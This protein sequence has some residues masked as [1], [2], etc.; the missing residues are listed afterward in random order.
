[1]GELP[2]TRNRTSAARQ[3]AIR[4][5]VR[6]AQGIGFDRSPSRI[7]QPSDADALFR[8]L[9][10]PGIHA[11]IYNLPRPLTPESVGAFIARKQQQQSDGVGRLL[12]RFDTHGEVLGYSEFDVWPEWGAGD[13]G[14]ALR[15]DQQGAR[16]GVN[17]AKQTFDW[18][19][20]VLRL[21]LV[22]ATGALDNIR[23]ARL[24]DDLGLA[25]KGEI[26]STREDG[27]TRQSIVWEVTK[28][29]W[30]GAKA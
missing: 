14:G 12:L 10:D 2:I 13:L 4:R 28:E 20:D 24:L 25:R 18:M 17:G 26:T 21:D 3:S 30:R 1:M 9:A 15:R 27:S 23:T 19:F 6:A 22:V 8:F 5:A 11:P 16:V 7:A 29:M